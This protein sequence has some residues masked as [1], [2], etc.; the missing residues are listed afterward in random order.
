MSPIANAIVSGSVNLAKALEAGDLLEGADVILLRR[1]REL[2]R[3]RDNRQ[4]VCQDSS[5]DNQSPRLHARLAHDL[6]AKKKAPE[7]AFLDHSHSIVPGGLL[8]TS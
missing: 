1:G 6:R 5:E 3:L 4:P 8:V 2:C 7:G